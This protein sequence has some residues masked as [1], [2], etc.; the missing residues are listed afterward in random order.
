MALDRDV[1]GSEKVDLDNGCWS[2]EDLDTKDDFLEVRF[3]FIIEENV[4]EIWK[5]K[6]GMEKR[7]ILVKYSTSLKIVEIV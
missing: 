3:E 7:E 1:V 4:W 2:G 5:N 6:N